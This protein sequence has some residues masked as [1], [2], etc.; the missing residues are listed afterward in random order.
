M[1]HIFIS[2][3]HKDSDYARRL[4]D[5]LREEGF[6]VWIDARIDYGSQWPLELQ[7]QLDTCDAFILIMSPRSY[8][9]EWVQSELQR[10][11]RKLK[12]IFPLLLEGNEPWLSVESTQYYDVQGEKLPESKFY[13]DLAH[14]VTRSEGPGV[15]LPVNE[16]RGLFR[17]KPAVGSL[18]VRTG[19]VVAIIAGIVILSAVTLPLIRSA[20][21][22]NGPPSP[23]AIVTSTSESEGPPS[24]ESIVTETNPAT[25]ESGQ[26]PVVSSDSIDPQGVPMGLV[27]AGAFTMGSRN[28]D[29]ALVECQSYDSNCDHSW[30]EDELVPHV[31]NLDAYYMDVYE[32]TNRRYADCVNA[33]A[34]EPP[35]ESSSDTRSSYFGNPSF[36][37]YPVIFIDWDMAKTYCEWRGA[38]LPTEAEWE[39]AA[40][41]TD[42]RTYPWGEEIDDTY[43]NYNGSVGDSSAVGSYENGKSPYGL[44]D[45]VGNVWD[46]VADFYSY[47][48][49]RESPSSNPQGPD[50]G[51]GRVLRGGSWYDPAYLNRTT[52]RLQQVHPVDN[53]YGFRCA[54][55]ATPTP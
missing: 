16:G 40:R 15:L 8:A 42:E 23:A 38:R 47:T 51:E 25:E 4:A 43:A 37:D 53:N 46:W 5:T 29:A 13:T 28:I 12:P 18:N 39:K 21:S 17:Q 32:V 54:R 27:P 7:K 20:F 50:S 31:V 22:Q 1:S 2:Y 36:D 3:S 11:R 34:C 52:T 41:S 55:D 44:Y 19:I 48:Y 26:V 10:A 33:G 24:P 6:D 49:Y 30:F 9:S 35:V 14:V 45:M